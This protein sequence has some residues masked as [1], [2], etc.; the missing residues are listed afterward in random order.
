MSFRL[1]PA[2]VLIAILLVVGGPFLL[3]LFTNQYVSANPDEI[4]LLGNSG[5]YFSFI[6]GLPVSIIIGIAG[7]F[8]GAMI[9]SRQ[10]D[11]ETLEFV[12]KKIEQTLQVYIAFTSSVKNLMI[13]GN[14]TTDIASDALDTVPDGKK[15][16]FE[17]FTRKVSQIFD[18]REVQKELDI[19]SGEL[20]G[21]FDLMKSDLYAP[22]IFQAQVKFHDLETSSDPRRISPFAKL[23]KFLPSSLSVDESE[24]NPDLVTLSNNL[25]RWTMLTRAEEAAVAWYI[26]PQGYSTVDIVGSLLFFRRF[27]VKKAAESD[28]DSVIFNIGAAH[29][30]RLIQLFPQK[31]FAIDVF[32]KI[33]D[34]RSPIARRFLDVAGPELQNIEGRQWYESLYSHLERKNTL[35]ILGYDG[36]YVHASESDAEFVRNLNFDI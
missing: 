5:E 24:F 4:S 34:G 29:I 7:A 25:I 19:C 1:W 12:E 20:H 31:K 10:G 32:D 30:Q 11:V 14:R 8:L 23:K 21:A 33:L 36:D 18:E 13:A 28:P 15:I 2:A 26:M 6:I 16:S 35:V 9:A 27:K 17:D 3:N 22:Q